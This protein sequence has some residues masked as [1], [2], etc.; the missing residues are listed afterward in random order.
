MTELFEFFHRQAK[1]NRKRRVTFQTEDGLLVD[2]L[3]EVSRSSYSSTAS[4]FA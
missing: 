2:T 4:S 1:K 3:D